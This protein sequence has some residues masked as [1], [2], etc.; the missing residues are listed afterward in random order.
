MSNKLLLVCS[1]LLVA[2][3]IWYMRVANTIVVDI[4][5]FDEKAQIHLAEAHQPEGVEPRWFTIEPGKQRLKPNSYHFRLSIE[6]KIYG[7]LIAVHSSNPIVL[8]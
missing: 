2:V 1:V 6:D 4:R 8:K 7:G 3:G 5:S